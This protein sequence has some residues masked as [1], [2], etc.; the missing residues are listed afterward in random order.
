MG[1]HYWCCEQLGLEYKALALKYHP[2]RV[3][4]G[5]Q[6][7]QHEERFKAIANA[8]ELLIQRNT[9]APAPAEATP[10]ANRKNRP[11][12]PTENDMCTWYRSGGRNMRN[13]FELFEHEFRDVSSVTALSQVVFDVRWATVPRAPPVVQQLPVT[14]LELFTGCTKQVKLPDESLRNLRLAPGIREGTALSIS[15]TASKDQRRVD[16]TFVLQLAEAHPTF[17]RRGNHLACTVAAGSKSV[18]LRTLDGRDLEIDLN[19]VEGACVAGEGMPILHT[20]GLRGNLLI[21]IGDSVGEVEEAADEVSC[22]VCSELVPAPNIH[23]H[24]VHCKRHLQ[25]GDNC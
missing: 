24:L 5:P 17:E 3:E 22:P 18:S 13:P 21:Q 10:S 6:R 2:D 1:D 12:A 4:P 8:Y 19:P 23:L 14:L 7:E 25:L 9:S 16:A 11:A 15:G 20:D